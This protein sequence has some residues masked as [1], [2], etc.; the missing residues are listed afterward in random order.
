MKFD[1]WT[2]GLIIAAV[3]LGLAWWG[4]RASRAKKQKRPL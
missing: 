3:V 2:I 4:K 1:A